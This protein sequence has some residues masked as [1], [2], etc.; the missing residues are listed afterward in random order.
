MF[1]RGKPPLFEGTIFFIKKS[2]WKKIQHKEGIDWI[3]WQN[4]GFN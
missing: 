3:N 4:F 2:T 1:D